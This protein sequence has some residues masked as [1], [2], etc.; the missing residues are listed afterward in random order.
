M[1]RPVGILG[2]ILAR[3]PAFLQF[4]V[5]AP[6]AFRWFLSLLVLGSCVAGR[7]ADGVVRC[8]PPADGP[9]QR[10]SGRL[11]G[12]GAGRCGGACG[13][14]GGLAGHLSVAVGGPAA[15]RW[16]VRV[17]SRAQREVGWGSANSANRAGQRC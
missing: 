7:W 12:S 5:V 9:S 15:A 1:A 6:G 2:A 3:F 10:L 14:S 17:L 16:V 11:P 13:R 4:S 8:R